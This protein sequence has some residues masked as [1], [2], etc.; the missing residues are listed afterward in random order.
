MTIKEIRSTYASLFLILSFI[1]LTS[2]QD[3]NNNNCYGSGSIAAAVLGTLVTTILLLL[4]I[5]YG[6]CAIIK[7]RKGEYYIYQ[8]F[9]SLI[10]ITYEKLYI[11][12]FFFLQKST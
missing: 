10:T 2:A 8:S 12:W 5:F 3:N 4:L 1:N 11:I 7:A 6:Y 9:K